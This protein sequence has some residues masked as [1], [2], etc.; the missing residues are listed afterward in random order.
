M[1]PGRLR[2]DPDRLESLLSRR[3]VSYAAAGLVVPLIG[4]IMA[5][6]TIEVR[7][8][9]R[10]APEIQRLLAPHSRAEAPRAVFAPSAVAPAEQLDL[11]AFA[12]D[13][14]RAREAEEVAPDDRTEPQAGPTPAP[15][16]PEPRLRLDE[17]ARSLEPVGRAHDGLADPSVTEAM[18]L[19]AR[20]REAGRVA[21]GPEGS[22]R[23]IP[24]L[25]RGAAGAGGAGGTGVRPG[26]IPD[27]G[28][29]GTTAGRSGQGAP[30]G[31]D[32]A[33][34][35]GVVRA[36][37]PVFA[38]EAEG[39][40]ASEKRA[41]IDWIAANQAPLPLAVAVALEE[42]RVKFDRTA[43]T[44]F[45]DSSGAIWRA[46]LL[47]RSEKDLVRLLLVRDDRAWRLDLPEREL[48]A[49]HVQAGRVVLAGYGGDPAPSDAP[50][51]EVSL[52]A[53]TRVPRPA[54][55]GL[56][57]VRGWIGGGRM[58]EP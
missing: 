1:S 29:A 4:L 55:D 46:F 14:R 24:E 16:A 6:G 19:L 28:D 41:L 43:V 30:T 54:R 33:A 21:M 51:I 18:G 15:S 53:V 38:A 3:A 47:H 36:A 40:L 37:P 48:A 26:G 9:R 5:T 22:G 10:S 13:R 58:K 34:A 7:A 44:A 56:S 35:P 27:A 2:I 11:E 50:I 31:G 17:S 42:D 32:R 39:N 52:A 23:G 20:D 45:A 57:L 25:R 49:D 12:E 8:A